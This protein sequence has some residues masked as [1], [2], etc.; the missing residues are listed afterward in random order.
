[1][2]E[3]AKGTWAGVIAF[4]L[5]GF[6]PL[7]FLPLLAVSSVQVIAH[8]IAWSFLV[9]FGWMGLRHELR[10]VWAALTQ[11]RIALRLMLSAALITANWLVYVW[12]VMHGH[13]VEASLG[14]FINPLV[15]V[16]LGIV[17]L[18]ER[19]DRVQAIAVLL[20]S[21]GVA[22]L[23]YETGH[24]PWISL[25]LAFSFASYGFIRKIVRV[26]A[27]PGLAAETLLLLPLAVGY[28][29]W[30]EANGTADFAHRSTTIDVLLAGTGPLTAVTLFLFAY[31]TRRI[32]YSTVGVLQY[33]A[34]T[35][36]LC[37]G[38]LVMHE[39]FARDRLVGFALIWAAL[40]LYAADGLRRAR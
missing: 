9:V 2:R 36:Q 15:N 13:V 30:C 28:L 32:P 17:L 37:C 21:A 26:D 19:L 39:P 33:I 6:F 10:D 12:A 38:V 25:C 1:V 24:L 11:W 23:T 14:Y 3:T 4:A 5:W 34:P 27:L 29:V 8:R 7:Y 40:I 18:G 31:A 35:L 16:L 20:A 22:D